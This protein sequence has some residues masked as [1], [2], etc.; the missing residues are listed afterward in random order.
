MDFD[1]DKTLP[2]E[3]RRKAVGDYVRAHPH[4][5]HEEAERLADYLLRVNDTH[6]GGDRSI[7]TSNR[8][9]TVSKRECRSIDA[10]ADAF[11]EMPFPSNQVAYDSPLDVTRDP[12]T[13]EDEQSVPFLASYMDMLREFRMRCLEATGY[14]RYRMGRTLASMYAQAYMLRDSARGQVVSTVMP[15]LVHEMCHMSLPENVHYDSDSGKVVSDC[16]V[17]IYDERHVAM[18]LNWYCQLYEEVRDDVSSDMHWLLEDL[19]DLIT[20]AVPKRY[21]GFVRAR[22][23]GEQGSIEG[24]RHGGSYYSTLW[25]HRIPRMIADEAGR[26]WMKVNWDGPRR[27]CSRCGRR[28]PAHEFFFSRNM[29]SPDGF[30]SICKECRRASRGGAR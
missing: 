28:L 13:W 5:R 7:L 10:M 9:V 15:S 8:M 25:N 26:R 27:T 6:A 12:I 20:K 1:F 24:E 11:G 23:A 14:K 29:K 17:S 18:L 19:S 3:E 22:L 16:P 2:V 21:W 30:H 4:M